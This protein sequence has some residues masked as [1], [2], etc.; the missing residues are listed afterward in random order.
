MRPRYPMVFDSSP[1][2]YAMQCDNESHKI[3]SDG[4]AY[5][6]TTDLFDLGTCP[7]SSACS[8][9]DEV[10]FKHVSNGVAIESDSFYL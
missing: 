4:M 7:H 6:T 9:G 2:W 5:L 1:M 8:I 3:R 10:N